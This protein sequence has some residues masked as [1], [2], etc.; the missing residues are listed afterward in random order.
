MNVNKLSAFRELVS[1]GRRCF[2]HLLNRRKSIESVFTDI[3]L[4]GKWGK[5]A[6]VDFYSGEGS[7]QGQAVGQYLQLIR[8]ES[9]ELGFTGKRWLDLGCGDFR[10][11]GALRSLAGTYT[12]V[13]VVSPL[14]EHHRRNWRGLPVTFIQQDVTSGQPLPE[15]EVVFVRQVLQHLSNAQILL[16]LERL[17]AWPLVYITEHL[18]SQASLIGPN[19]DMSHGSGIRLYKGSGV[20]LTEAPFNVPEERM[21]IVLEV[22]V[23]FAG[24]NGDFG[25]L[26]TS[27]YRPGGHRAV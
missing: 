4:K 7:A 20:Y 2:E 19:K 5:E 3:Y 13:D 18:P 16:F 26:R 1:A 27:R 12:A 17:T 15:A 21:E 22:P 10:I 14:I 11:G 8:N 9:S 25:I 24:C 23:R 6:G